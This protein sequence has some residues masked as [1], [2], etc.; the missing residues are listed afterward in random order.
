MKAY[1]DY[2]Y[3]ML[4]SKYSRRQKANNV[5]HLS[6]DS[7]YALN[8]QLNQ[9]QNDTIYVYVQ[10]RVSL[11]LGRSLLYIV[12]KFG[13]PYCF[14]LEKKEGL[15]YEVMLYKKQIRG[16][17]TRITYHFLN[18]ELV[19]LNYYFKKEHTE[20][21]DRMNKVIGKLF[22]INVAGKDI[23]SATD[24]NNNAIEFENTIDLRI[25]LRTRSPQVL[26]LLS[27][28]GY[29]HTTKTYIKPVTN[30]ELVM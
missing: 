17:K 9:P 24:C 1:I 7:L 30:Y 3:A 12:G 16:I 2:F 23:Y 29:K 26:K 15:R 10:D 13:K 4:L 21:L 19:M 18:G 25:T 6:N 28:T 8:H 11:L 5:Q 14:R 20:E 27:K 22:G